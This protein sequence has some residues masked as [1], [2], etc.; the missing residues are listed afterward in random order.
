MAVPG[1]RTPGGILL[2]EF[3]PSVGILA[4]RIDTLGRKI[5]HFR[6]PLFASIKTVMIPSFRAN[7]KAQGRPA[8]EELS[9]FTVRMRNG[10]TGPI[11]RR[12]GRLERDAT[13]TK[14]WRITDTA[15][16]IQSWPSTSWYGPIHQTGLGSQNPSQAEL[17]LR[18][19]PVKM[20]AGVNVNAYAVNI[21]ARPFIMYQE[22][23]VVKIHKIFDEWLEEKIG[24]TWGRR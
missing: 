5:S 7:F 12:T 15:A 21:P 4:D 14:I 24:E 22:E 1:L 6:E 9:P 8:W 23:D 2:F 19:R 17:N 16:S 18:R 13:S 11:L 20:V 3:Q 10:D